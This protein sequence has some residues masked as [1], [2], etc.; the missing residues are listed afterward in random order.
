M[1][2]PASS[3]DRFGT[4]PNLTE[5]SAV[6][7]SLSWLTAHSGV[8]FSG[9]ILP[10]DSQ[11]TTAEP[12][13]IRIRVLHSIR[14]VGAGEVFAFAQWPGA[15][16]VSL[17]PNEHVILFLHQ[18]NAAGMS[19]SVFGGF[20]VLRI[21][22]GDLVDVLSLETLALHLPDKPLTSFVIRPERGHSPEREVQKTSSKV[23]EQ[24]FLAT[25]DQIAAAQDA[26]GNRYA[27]GHFRPLDAV[28]AR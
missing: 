28:Y 26:G 23:A 21:G 11:Q 14:G 17:T 15:D 19:S 7:E 16:H 24:A 2:P 13:E 8:I 22:G 1:C 3:Q 5:P 27:D 18:P 10:V 6:Y 12:R 25:V 9:I 4:E 20:G